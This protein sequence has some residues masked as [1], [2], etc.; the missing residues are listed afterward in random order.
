M[1]KLLLFLTSVLT[2]NVLIAQQLPTQ[3]PTQ[4]ATQQKQTTVG[5]LQNN[6]AQVQSNTFAPPPPPP[7]PRMEGSAVK[8][9]P[10]MQTADFALIENPTYE[11]G[12]RTGFNYGFSK[13]NIYGTS[14]VGGNGL[15]TTDFTQRAV[16]IFKSYSNRWFYSIS[17]AQV[18]TNQT[19]GISVTRLWTKGTRIVGTQVSYSNVNGSSFKI[20]SPAF[21]VFVNNTYSFGRLR[22]TPELYNTFSNW[23]YDRSKKS[24]SNDL[25]Y[26]AL[27][28]ATF[29]YKF[30]RRFV[31]SAAY[32]GNINTNPKVGV[33]NNILIGS[34]FKF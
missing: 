11:G 32:R 26:N 24:W 30:T 12:F 31:L 33:M 27:V 15:F 1:K 5:Q 29:S 19:E 22:I 3:P 34:S 14:T 4:S 7:P 8:P 2:A 25:T 23:Y 6:V 9:N 17:Y 21:V 18:G 13:S 28:G 10:F 16:S 20:S